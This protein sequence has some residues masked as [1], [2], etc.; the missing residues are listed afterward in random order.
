MIVGSLALACPQAV[1]LLGGP[2]LCF[3]FIQGAAYAVSGLYGLLSHKA[4]ARHRGT[5]SE[6][7]GKEE[8]EFL[9]ELAAISIAYPKRRP[10]RS[11]VR[12]A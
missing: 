11:D 6:D 2:S 10:K 9:L 7:V 8:A 5:Q 4:F 12:G 1:A 3:D